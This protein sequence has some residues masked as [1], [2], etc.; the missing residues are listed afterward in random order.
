MITKLNFEP[1]RIA[2][3]MDFVPYITTMTE[4]YNAKTLYDG[5]DPEHPETFETCYDQRVYH[6]FLE[7]GKITDSPLESL[8]RSIHDHFVLKGIRQLIA[9]YSQTNVVGVMGGSAMRRD[10]D[11]Y[12]SIAIISKKLTE[13][14]SLMVSGGGSGAMEATMLGGLMAGRTMK[15]L[16]DALSIL[17]EAPMY[18]KEGYMEASFKVIAKYPRI[19]D[20]ECLSIPTWLYGHEPT[21][22]FASHIGKLFENS[23][24]EDL[25]LT[26]AMGGVIYTPGSAGTMQEV[27]QEAVQNH[28]LIF[29]FAS[30][31]V[32]LGTKF[33]TEDMPAYSMLTQL[34][35]TGKYKNLLLSITDDPDEVVKIIQDFETKCEKEK[36]NRVEYDLRLAK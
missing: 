14:G 17:A 29:G 11:S 35:K 10:D 36:L 15:E 27:F 13:G 1:G 7:S 19:G 8:S 32:F 21:S 5:Y 34:S 30:P 9:C 24:R 26:I 33:W 4:L 18:G 12:R 28:Y 16:D 6:Y 22:P 23:V 20:Y 31:M 2:N 25:L 3:Y